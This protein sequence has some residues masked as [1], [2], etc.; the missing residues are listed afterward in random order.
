MQ[1]TYTLKGLDCASCAAKIE[2][3]VKLSGGVSYASLNFI[4]GTLKVEVEESA[5]Q[6]ITNQI[7]KIV[8]KYEPD[9]LVIPYEKARDTKVSHV[10]AANRSSEENHNHDYHDHDH[11]HDHEDNSRVEAVKIIIGALIYAAGIILSNFFQANQTALMAIY[12]IS[13]IILGGRVLLR[14]FRNILRGQVFDENFLMGI[15]TLGALA[16][17]K[18]PE[19]MAVMLFYRVGEYFQSMAVRKSKK[20]ISELMDIRPDYANIILDGEEVKVDP[21]NVAIGDIILVKPGEKIPLDG[22][23]TEGESMLDTKALT[24]ESLPREAGPSDTVLSGCINLNGVLTIEVTKT[25]GESTAAKII[26]LVENAGSKKAPTEQFITKFARHYTPV[27]VILAALIAIIPPLFFG[28]EWVD[29]IHRGLVFLVI[30]CPCALVISIP[31]GFFGGIGGASRRGILVKGGN[32]LEA[33][34]ELDIIVFDKTGTLTKGVFSVTDI[35]TAVEFTEDEVLEAA[36]AAEAFSNH[37]IARS[38]L[39]AYGGEIDKAALCDYNEIPGKGISVKREGKEILAG[40]YKLMTMMNI[41]YQ[42]PQSLGTKVYIAKDGV[43]AGCI[44]IADEI[45]PDSKE[46]VAALKRKGV[47][48]AVML[49]G[50]NMQI[51]S[52]IASELQLD[53]AYGELLPDHKVEMVEDLLERRR[54]KGKLAFVGD[55]INDAP[56]L[57]RADIGIAMGALGQDAA[58]EAADVVLMTDE[59]SKIAEAVDVARFTKRIVRQNIVISL[60]VKGV[61]LVLGAFGVASMWEAVFADVG[62]ALIAVLN[63]TRVI[64]FRG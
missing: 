2:D 6:S 49:S 24:G 23:I 41:P 18:L 3:A 14:A 12:L 54:P 37:P 7:S 43:F 32:Y 44:T 30:S 10:N 52:A 38:I 53:E 25:F 42:E 20:S 1:K 36:A 51:A 64:N 31:L 60:G 45:K 11:H 27:V 61:F 46:A 22:I 4:N 8:H 26:D 15:A 33:L 39:N 17:G 35:Q 9:V 34:S 28:G 13:Y 47:R 29:W 21:T 16:I 58:I 55:G 40:N 56:V 48:K 62:V 59:P 5:C 63:A 50:D 57:A 19:A